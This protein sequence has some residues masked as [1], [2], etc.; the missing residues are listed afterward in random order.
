MAHFDELLSSP[1]EFHLKGT[2]LF[3]TAIGFSQTHIFGYNENKNT[4][5]GFSYRVS[6]IETH[7]MRPDKKTTEIFNDKLLH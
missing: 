1:Q 2:L 4:C 7:L 5:R 6:I 3:S